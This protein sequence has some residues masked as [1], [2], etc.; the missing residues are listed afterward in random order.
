MQLSST[1]RFSQLIP[2]RFTYPR[3]HLHFVNLVQGVLVASKNVVIDVVHSHQGCL[4]C[5]WV[6]T[7]QFPIN[8]SWPHWDRMA[9]P[10]LS[11]AKEQGEGLHGCSREALAGRQMAGSFRTSPGALAPKSRPMEGRGLYLSA[12]AC[13]RNCIRT[14]DDFCSGSK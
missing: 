1:H 11:K 10:E 7:V 8:Q 3:P 9:A 6:I 4:L 12:G 2:S 14:W 5:F 13:W